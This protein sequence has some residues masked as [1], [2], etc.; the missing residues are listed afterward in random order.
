MKENIPFAKP[1]EAAVLVDIVTDVTGG[2]GVSRCRVIW[3]VGYDQDTRVFVRKRGG[4]GK[5]D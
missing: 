3:I 4:R 1:H 2:F 5:G